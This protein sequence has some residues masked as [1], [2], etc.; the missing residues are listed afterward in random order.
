LMQICPCFAKKRDK[1]YQDDS[2]KTHISAGN[3][4]VH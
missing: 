3:T 1:A 2:S 4:E